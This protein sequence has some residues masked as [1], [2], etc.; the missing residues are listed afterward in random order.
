VIVTL[1]WFVIWF[2]CDRSATAKGCSSTRSTGGPERYSW[3][4]HSTWA[5]T[6]QASESA[7]RGTVPIA[8]RVE[9]SSLR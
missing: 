1:V 8:H 6:T 5:A 3:P 4:Q 2:I 7:K 9:A